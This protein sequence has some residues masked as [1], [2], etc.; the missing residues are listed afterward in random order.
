MTSGDLWN[1]WM[2]TTLLPVSHC[3][4]QL[5]SQCITCEVN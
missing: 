4:Y 3:V 5:H 1:P 2:H